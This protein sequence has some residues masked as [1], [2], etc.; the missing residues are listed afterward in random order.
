MINFQID[1]RAYVQLAERRVANC[2]GNQVDADLAA[3]GAG[4]QSD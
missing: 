1:G 4:Q 3:L 2:V